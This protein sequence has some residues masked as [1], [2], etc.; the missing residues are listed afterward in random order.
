VLPCGA[1]DAGAFDLGELTDVSRLRLF[2]FDPADPT[3][4]LA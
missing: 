3:V 2:A 1:G 4:L